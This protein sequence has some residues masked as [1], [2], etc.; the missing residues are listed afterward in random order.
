M[1]GNVIDS[2]MLRL[3]SGSCLARTGLSTSSCGLREYMLS[4]STMIRVP[5]LAVKKRDSMRTFHGQAW[6]FL[7]VKPIAKLLSFPNVLSG[8]AI[9]GFCTWAGY[10]LYS[11]PKLS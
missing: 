1:F 10:S 7:E 5:E 6:S 9:V 11:E 3:T 2:K 4:T 8:A